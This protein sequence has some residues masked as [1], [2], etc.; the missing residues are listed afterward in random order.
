M[1]VCMKNKFIFIAVDTKRKKGYHLLCP[2]AFD[3]FWIQNFLPAMQAL[4]IC[5]PFHAFR[6]TRRGINSLI[7][8][9]LLLYHGFFLSY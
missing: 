4:D 9:H 6:C 8:F 5:P 1:L 2:R 7:T 3:K